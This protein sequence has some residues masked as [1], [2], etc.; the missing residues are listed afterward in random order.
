[1]ELLNAGHCGFIFLCAPTFCGR[2]CEPGTLPPDQANALTLRFA[3]PFFLRYVAGRTRFALELVPARAP[4][5]V[6]VEEAH[7]RP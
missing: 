7:P 5:G 3:V 6:R 2:G 1:M 4:S